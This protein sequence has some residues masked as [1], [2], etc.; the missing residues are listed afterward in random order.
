MEGARANDNW[1]LSLLLVQMLEERGKSGN[2]SSLDATGC[3]HVC[4]QMMKCFRMKTFCLHQMKPT[5][6]ISML[7]TWQT[8]NE[9]Y[10]WSAQI[11][12]FSSHSA[13]R[14]R[15]NFSLKFEWDDILFMMLGRLLSGGHY[16][17]RKLEFLFQL[18][19]LHV[20]F[21]QPW[22]SSFFKIWNYIFI[23]KVLNENGKLTK[24]SHAVS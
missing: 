2:R 3:M 22:I 4:L 20:K 14:V 1:N 8:W 7:H 24:K 16:Y 17:W 9:K 12:W 21:K 18:V 19:R 6:I 13:L 10:P 5:C 11:V 15:G 23:Q